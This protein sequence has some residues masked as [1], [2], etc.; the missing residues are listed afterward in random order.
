MNILVPCSLLAE[1][2]LSVFRSAHLP[3]RYTSKADFP[4]ATRDRKREP[5]PQRYVS[6]M[7][8]TENF[9]SQIFF[10]VF[11]KPLLFT[12]HGTCSMFITSRKYFSVFQSPHL[13]L[14]TPFL[15]SMFPPCNAISEGRLPLCNTNSEAGA[16]PSEVR[17]ENDSDR[18]FSKSIFFQSFSGN[19]FSSRFMV[20]CSLLAENIFRFFEVRTPH[21]PLSGIQRISST[22]PSIHHFGLEASTLLCDLGR[23]ASPLQHELGSGS[24]ALR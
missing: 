15:D 19:H 6:R 3:P 7:I 13:P 17:I 20:P 4:F 5:C 14:D 18:K 8:R 9:L 2:I 22:Y 11:W 23:Q 12:F 21:L 24:P 1:N 16:L 10:K